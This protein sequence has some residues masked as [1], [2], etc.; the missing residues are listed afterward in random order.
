MN[1]CLPCM[2][3]RMYVCM[4]A[5]MHLCMHACIYASEYP[6]QGTSNTARN[7]ALCA[8]ARNL[9]FYHGVCTFDDLY[10]LKSEN[11]AVRERGV[12]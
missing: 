9:R 5:R 2:P 6:W 3:A 10:F 11:W 8:T 7:S 1:A 12:G 4:H